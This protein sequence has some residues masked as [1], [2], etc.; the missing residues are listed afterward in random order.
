MPQKLTEKQLQDMAAHLR[1]PSGPEGLT[2]AQMMNST[3]GNLIAKT[4]DALSIGNDDTILE[5]GP[6]NGQHVK[7]I[8]AKADIVQYTGADISETMI[9]EARKINADNLKADFIL[10]NGSTLPFNAAIFTKVFTT[11]TIYFWEDATAFCHEIA[12]IL[13]PGGK[14]SLGYIPER[15]M[16]NIPFSKY[17][18]TLYSEESVRELLEISGFEILSETI[19]KEMV[20]SNTGNAIEREFVVIL[21]KKC[22]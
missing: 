18:F 22:S 12:R 3:N 6:G 17:G 10:T 20:T 7:D 1:C 11:N 4:M 14:L 13:Q 5:I 19:E 21:A 15:V 2:V 16:K 9:Q 8:F